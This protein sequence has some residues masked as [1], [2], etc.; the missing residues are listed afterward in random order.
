MPAPGF[1]ELPLIGLVPMAARRVM[2]QYNRG[3][4]DHEQK[5]GMGDRD[6]DS[7]INEMGAPTNSYSNAYKKE[8]KEFA[9][10]CAAEYER[11]DG[12]AFEGSSV[13]A[14]AVEG[15]KRL[16]LKKEEEDEEKKLEIILAYEASP[17]K[18]EQRRQEIM[19]I[20]LEYEKLRKEDNEKWTLEVKAAKEAGLKEGIAQEKRRYLDIE[21][22][23]EDA[24]KKKLAEEK[25]ARSIEVERMREAERK[26]QA[27]KEK[28]AKTA[29]AKKRAVAEAA[30]AAKVR[31]EENAK[32]T[33][34]AQQQ[35]KLA[36]DKAAMERAAA[37]ARLVLDRKRKSEEQTAASPT[38]KTKSTNTELLP[39]FV[40]DVSIY[41]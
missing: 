7:A 20:K 41:H 21:E 30:E 39:I 24:R 4:Q 26:K 37:A 34:A 14:L 22:K 18:Q 31:M 17:Q 29:E 9:E 8:L 6:M 16:Q 28:R 32:K 35:K 12:F 5:P 36:L 19:G 3:K 38:K 15:R 27:I 13:P 2:E 25:A 23:R 40:D 11:N 33:A 10:H 1:I